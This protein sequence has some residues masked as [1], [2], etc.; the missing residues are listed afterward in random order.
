ML[1][2]QTSTFALAF[3]RFLG[4]RGVPKFVS[5]NAKAF[6]SEETKKFLRDRGISYNFDL[7]RPP[8]SGGVFERII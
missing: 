7:A 4:R 5:D 3:R 6:K 2:G 1:L 8:W